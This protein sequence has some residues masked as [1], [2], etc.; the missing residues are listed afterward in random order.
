MDFFEIFWINMVTILMISA[1]LPTPGLLKIKTC[2]NKV[3]DVIVLGYDVSNKVL[4]RDSNYILDVVMWPKFGNSSISIRE[5]IV[6]SILQEFDQK[7]HFFW[8][9]VLVQVEKFGTDT[10][11][12]F[13]ILH[14]CGKRVKTKSQ[15]VLWAK[16]NI[17]RSYRKETG[18]GNF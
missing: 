16:S 8:G 12:D 14:R 17:C 4:S 2:Q 7:S 3:Y 11:Y 10:N 6:T 5:V 9:E 18:T 13:E 1:N 15:K